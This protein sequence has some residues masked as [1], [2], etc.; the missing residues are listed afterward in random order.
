LRS[1]TPAFAF[2]VAV[3]LIAACGDDSGGKD[4]TDAGTGTDSGL[5]ADAGSTDGKVPGVDSGKTPD[6]AV[7]DG[8]VTDAGSLPVDAGAGSAPTLSTA[9]AKQAGRFGTDLLVDVTGSDADKDIDLVSVVLLDKAGV[10]I[11]TERRLPIDPPITAVQGSAKFTLTGAL[12]GQ[13]ELGTAKVTLLDKRGV[14]SGTIDAAITAQPVLAAGAAC[15]A[16]FATNRCGEGLG[17]KGTGAAKTCSAGEAPTVT[18]VGYF[19]DEL[20]RRI[21]IEG[22][23]PDADAAKYTVSFLQEDGET[24]VLYDLDGDP[25]TPGLPSLTVVNG[26][27]AGVTSFF[28]R[29]T[30]DEEF[31]KLVKRVGVTVSDAR[32]TANTSP[33]VKSDVIKAAPSKSS[34][35]G[36]SLHAFDYCKGTAQSPLVCTPQGSDGV[37]KP[38]AM[39]RT[40]ACTA[41]PTLNPGSNALSV[42]GKLGQASLWDTP[43]A[44]SAAKSMPDAV[45][46][47]V[48]ASTAAKV[49]LTTDFSYTSFNSEITLFKSSGTAGCGEIPDDQPTWCQADAIVD[50]LISGPQP[51]LVLENLEA[52]SYFVLVDSFP[53]LEA[54]GELFQ[55]D[56]KVE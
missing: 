45:V 16:T 20:G 10:Q 22:T 38:L 39:A 37:C 30:P 49:T 52:G 14:A 50:G 23:D 1:S 13:T 55:L 15:D 43:A 47:F 41:A 51:T 21:V 28:F 29:V 12:E 24:A 18:K 44:C 54:T 3:G 26:E 7:T 40:A 8:A 42:R 6:G 46:K 34:G 17:C 2:A 31:V 53:S 48:L 27:S 33:V 35:A 56:V 5:P 9:T 4:K 11:G 32:S 19:D 25:S 36:C